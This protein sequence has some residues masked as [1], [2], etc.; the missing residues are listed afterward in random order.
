MNRLKNI[1]TS[2]AL[3]RA[4]AAVL[5]LSLVGGVFYSRYASPK[6]VEASVTILTTTGSQTW[7]VPS[8]WNNSNNTIEV[9]GG[10]GGSSG[11][12]AVAKGLGGGAGAGGGY[13]KITNIT[14]PAGTGVTISIGSAGSAVTYGSAASNGGNTWVCNS[15]SSCASVSDTNVVVSAT[16]GGGGTSSTGGAAGAASVGTG[17][18]GGAGGSGGAGTGQSG[19]GGGGGGG[20]AGLNAAGNTGAANS[21]ATGG[22]G[23]RGDGTTGGTAGTASGGA[24]G[25]GAEWTT[26]GS[27]GGGGGGNGGGNGAVGNAGGTS[28]QYGA[29]GG[30]G[31]APGNGV[32]TAGIGKAGNQG[33][34]IV[35]YTPADVTPPSPN[36]PYFTVLPAPASVSSISMTSVTETDTDSPPTQYYFGYSACGGANDGTGGTDSGWQS[37]ASYTDTGLDA[38]KCYGFLIKARDSASPANVTSTS[39]TAT[40]TYTLAN[41]P[42]A[43][44]IASAAAT[45]VVLTNNENG[46]PTANPSTEFAVQVT[47]TSPTDSTWLNKY[48]TSGGAASGTTVWLSDSQLTNV[49]INNLSPNT[50]YTF[51][52]MA[53][54]FNAIETASSSGTSQLTLPGTPGTPTFS[55]II[56]T[57]LTVTWT[58]PTGGADTYKVERCTDASCSTTP[59]VIGAGVAGLSQSDSG[60][61]AGT[62]YW[63]RVRATN[64]TGDSVYSTIASV[65]TTSSGGGTGTTRIQGVRLR[66]GVRIQ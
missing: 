55:S 49:T 56:T 32:T 50:T 11:S 43:P 8:D 7:N 38:N 4:G 41:V 46:N 63:Y 58:A 16:G 30:A 3:R 45:T 17:F 5:A 57:S 21:G 20:A 29:G 10:G 36:P 26:A 31:G 15:T 28:G 12:Q 48:V 34:I 22:A 53:R 18:N 59:T 27:G 40:T 37:S 35:T 1:L 47:A 42:S 65:T 33:V 61:A 6:H 44:T 52:S 13:S 14:L 54:N 9:L 2:V 39:T 51:Q 25:N 23:G 60:L 19:G 62:T 24:G 64:A 66:G